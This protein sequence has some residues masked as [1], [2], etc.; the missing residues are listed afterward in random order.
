MVLLCL[1]IHQSI[2]LT[3]LSHPVMYIYR[4]AQRSAAVVEILFKSSF[5]NGCLIMDEKVFAQS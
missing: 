3:F 5:N 2:Q 4:N 1:N